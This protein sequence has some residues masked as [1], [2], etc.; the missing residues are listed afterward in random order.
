MRE[1]ANG[2]PFLA[3]HLRYEM[4]MLSFSGCTHGCSPKEEKQLTDLR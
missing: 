1:R 4:D 3:L 2:D